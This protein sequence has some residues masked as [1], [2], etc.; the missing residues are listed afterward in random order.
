MSKKKKVVAKKSPTKKKVAKKK[1]D[2]IYEREK[3]YGDPM[4]VRP[5]SDYY[6]VETG[7][8]YPKVFFTHDT[9]WT[10]IKRFFGFVP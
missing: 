3:A 2:N 5:V 7:E 1:C 10:K 8:N 4:P 6:N 9:I